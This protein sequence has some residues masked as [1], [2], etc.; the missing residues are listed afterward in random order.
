MRDDLVAIWRAGVRA[1][2][3]EVLMPQ[4]IVLKGDRLCI[5]DREY[6]LDEVGRII[7]LGAGKASGSMAKHLEEIL[8]P[9]AEAKRLSGWVNVPED[10]VQPLKWGHLHGARPSGVNEPTEKGVSG[11]SEILGRVKLMQ[12]SD[13]CLFL[14]SGGG[15]ALLPAPVEEITLPDKIAVTRFL[16]AAG[17]EIGQLNTV[18]KQLSR[19][20]GGKLKRQCRQGRLI[21]LVL[22][23]VLG[24]PLDLIASGPTVDDPSTPQQAL[25][26]LHDFGAQ[27][28]GIADRVFDYL[29]TEALRRESKPQ[30]GGSRADSRR[31][32]NFVIGNNAVAVD[33]AGMEA[34][35]R[36][37]SHA[38]VSAT[39]SEPTAEEVGHHLAEMALRM[40]SREG[41]D[42]L[43]SGGEPVVRLC[44][45]AIRGKGGRNQQLV[46][47]AMLHL[48]E[49]NA[50]E[51]IAMLSGGTDGEDG[52]TDAAG[53]WF[54]EE[55]FRRW[56]SSTL[57]AADHLQRNDAYPFFESLGSLL[58]SGPTGTNV[59]DLRVVLVDRTP[60]NAKP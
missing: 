12:D 35:R 31:V 4:T 27:E 20:K 11:T 39:K 19:V 57:D 41:A 5:E 15:S 36:G 43:I 32:E 45:E 33:A 1:V 37:Y 21:G 30:K 38:M 53:A 14:L 47:A 6:P 17:A 2:S 24:D 7:V 55:I 25:E 59:C 22:S 8:A 23:D 10:C 50:G 54:D 28:A 48:A 29:K 46:L 52:P 40:R 56:Q 51:G 3:S 49:K 60:Y 16:S 58:H 44:P 13:L 18:R 42:C 26:I 34:E 9:V